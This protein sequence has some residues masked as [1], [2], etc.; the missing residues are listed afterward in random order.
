M[1]FGGRQRLAAAALYAFALF[2]LPG[3]SGDQQA[4]D[5]VQAEDNGGDDGGGSGDNQAAGEDNSGGD[6]T[7]GEGN[8]ASNEEAGANTAEAGAGN[9]TENDLQDIIQEMNGQG[10]DAA[11]AGANAAPLA[12]DTQTPAAPAAPA[13][14]AAA[15]A[16]AAQPSADVAATPPPFQPG[17][18]SAGKSLPE[19]GSKMAYVVQ[20]GDTLAKISQKIYGV[21]NRWNELAT[22]SQLANPSRIFPGDLI[23]YTLD[24]SAVPFATAYESIARSEEHVNQGDTL[25]S[26]AKRVYGSSNAWRALWRENDHIDNPDIIP[27]G[28]TVF[29]VAHGAATAALNKIHAHTTTLAKAATTKTNFKKLSNKSK[30]TGKNSVVSKAKAAKH[31]NGV[32]LATSQISYGSIDSLSRNVSAVN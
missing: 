24:E 30:S 28:S 23:Y 3:C 15:A 1:R 7:A 6:N 26:I 29:Y 11:P 21:G 2:G 14:N 25:A 9:A 17:G 5:V 27:P 8:A 19:V 4:D 22:L 32:F 12:Q 20:K 13:D 18:T 31:A 10:A 16:P